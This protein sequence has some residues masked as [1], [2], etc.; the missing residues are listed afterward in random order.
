LF[1]ISKGEDVTGAQAVV[2]GHA[3]TNGSANFGEFF[4][5]GGVFEV[6]QSRA[7]IFFRNQNAHQSQF[8]EGFE[9]VD[10]EGL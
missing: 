4:D 10:G 2:G 7:V 5:A 8:A 1:F 6:R 9:D 3:Q